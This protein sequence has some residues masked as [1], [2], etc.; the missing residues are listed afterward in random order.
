[1]CAA[2]GAYFA[3]HPH[4]SRSLS[5]K[6]GP[7]KPFVAGR[8]PPRRASHSCP[9]MASV[10]APLFRA[11]ALKYERC[12]L[13]EHPHVYFA[14]RSS[15]S[16][17]A[18]IINDWWPGG[19]HPRSWGADGEARAAAAIGEGQGLGRSPAQGRPSPAAMSRG[20][21]PLCT[22]LGRLLV[23]VCVLVL[24]PTP[25]T[26]SHSYTHSVRMLGYLA[27]VDQTRPAHPTSCPHPLLWGAKLSLPPP[28][29]AHWCAPMRWV[30]HLLSSYTLE[31]LAMSRLV[32]LL[33]QVLVLRLPA[34][35]SRLTHTRRSSAGFSR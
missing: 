34:S 5:R 25:S 17:G 8:D 31:L 9:L 6:A 20:I 21:R 35:G 22:P 11:K 3:S 27:D 23:L 4:V 15:P 13:T 7:L 1:M 12:A 16:A 18:G 28:Y 2:L 14:H 26:S 33:V 24:A 32:G 19:G 10:R 30:S 29:V